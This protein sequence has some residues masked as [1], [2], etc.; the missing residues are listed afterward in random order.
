MG[1]NVILGAEIRFTENENDYLIFGISPEGLIDIYKMLSFGIDRFYSEYKNEKNIIIQA[2]PFRD[3][4]LSVKRESLDGIEVFNMHPNHNSRIGLAAKS[5]SDNM[6]T[7]CGSD[8]HHQGQE[9][10][11]GLLTKKPLKT[12]YDVASVLKSRK[13]AMS[14]G[15]YLINI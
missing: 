5:A 15:N 4:M 10:M 3:G 6:I 11:C 7:T 13:Y 14:I 12:S 8:F 1:L 2:H 9:C